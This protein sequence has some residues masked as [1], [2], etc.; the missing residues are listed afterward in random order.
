MSPTYRTPFLIMDT[1]RKHG[2]QIVPT[3]EPG[4]QPWTMRK[5]QV[6][7]GS[8]E[9]VTIAITERRDG[10]LTHVSLI[11]GRAD[12]TIDAVHLG[13]RYANKRDAVLSW[14][15]EPI[16]WTHWGIRP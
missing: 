14:L 15:S 5:D 10:G 8:T 16:D 13:P 4:K 12:I 7:A 2:W 9:R 3:P 11:R 1:A 6:Y